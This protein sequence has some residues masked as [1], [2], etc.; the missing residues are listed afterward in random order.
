MKFSQ[1]LVINGCPIAKIVPDNNKWVLIMTDLCLIMVNRC[2]IMM[3]LCLMICDRC[4]IMMNYC[5]IMMIGYLMIKT[6]A[7]L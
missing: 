4:L 1:C 6:N 7:L 5:L 2:L 3:D